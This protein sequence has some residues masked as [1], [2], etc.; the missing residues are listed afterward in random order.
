MQGHLYPKQGM[1]LLN[2]ASNGVMR[3]LWMFLPSGTFFNNTFGVKAYMFFNIT[4]QKEHWITGSI[5]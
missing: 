5:A 4:V 2:F 3:C 1:R